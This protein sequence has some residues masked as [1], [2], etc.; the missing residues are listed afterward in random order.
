M[1]GGS[2][3]E[4]GVSVLIF[5]DDAGDRKQLRRLLAQA[6][7]R[8]QVFEAEDAGAAE[9][10]DAC[11]PDLILLDHMLPGTTGLELMSRLSAPWPKAAVVMMTGQGS[12]EI[13]KE[14]ILNGAIDYLPKTG[15]TEELLRRVALS[16]IG[17]ARS[18]WYAAE[19][20]AEL[21]SFCDVLI[22]DFKAPIRSAEFLAEQIVE[23]LEDEDL[24]SLSQS[25]QLLQKTARQMSALVQSLATHIRAD[26]STAP[27]ERV[28]LERVVDTALT[29]LQREIAENGAEVTVDTAALLVCCNP[30]E[31]AQVLQNLLANAIKYAGGRRPEIRITAARLDR[32]DEPERAEMLRLCVADNG[33]GIPAEN[34][35]AVFDP[36]KRL[37]SALAV[38]GT[39]LGLATCRK[40]VKRYGGR[41]WCEPG[42]EV[43]TVF[44]IELPVDLPRAA[45]DVAPTSGQTARA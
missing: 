33:I 41:I 35:R 38:P 34:A 12:E 27:V 30:A 36:F 1:S 45:E 3:G 11:E 5:D 6:L 18:R 2:G 8:A 43:G 24:D 14:A 42:R 22:H 26:R 28:S 20:Q 23:D 13:A 25:A 29:A 9:A 10:F 32:P 15:L 21:S 31:L 7:P 44:C 4:A 37:P 19:R 40:V 16:S 39:G 17:I